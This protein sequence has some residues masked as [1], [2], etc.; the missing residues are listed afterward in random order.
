MLRV[1]FRCY[2]ETSVL[3]LATV[4]T[5]AAAQKIAGGPFVV[6]V[7]PRSATVVWIVHHPIASWSTAIRERATM[8]TV[9]SSMPS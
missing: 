5:L 6:N 2:E 4:V 7:T 9:A 3:V 8:C 1:D